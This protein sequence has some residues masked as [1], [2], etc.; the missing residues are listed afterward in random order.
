MSKHLPNNTRYIVSD[1]KLLPVSSMIFLPLPK[2]VA[3]LIVFVYE[4]AVNNAFS[5]TGCC[6]NVSLI[7]VFFAT[8]TPVMCEL[9]CLCQ[10]VLSLKSMILLPLPGDIALIIVLLSEIAVNNYLILTAC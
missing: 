10:R 8:E 6:C 7:S 5:L 9:D 2:D 3:L 4:S 1:K